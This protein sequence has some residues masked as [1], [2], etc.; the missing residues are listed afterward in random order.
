MYRRKKEKRVHGLVEKCG[1][2][3]PHGRPRYRWEDG[4]K[5][6]IEEV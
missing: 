6:D 5:R 2:K 1:E 3:R 4:M